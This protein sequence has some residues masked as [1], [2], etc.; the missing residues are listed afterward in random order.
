MTGS[1]QAK[2]LLLGFVPGARLS[3]GSSIGCV[4]VRTHGPEY[5]PS[6]T[7]TVLVIVVQVTPTAI[8]NIGWKTFIIFAC[9]CFAWVCLDK[10][11]HSCVLMLT[12]Q[13]PMVYFFFP[14][15]KGL[16]LEDV[17][18]LFDKGGITGGVFESRGHPVQPGVHRSLNTEII[19]KAVDPS[20]IEH[21]EV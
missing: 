14:E 10:I 1:I 3:P 12:V 11:S 6:D 2:L 8:D 4:S 5:R 19:A 20:H 21:A 13:I 17:D 9:F 7:L 15:T 18:H 16:E